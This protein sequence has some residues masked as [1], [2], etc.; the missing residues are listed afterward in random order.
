M[1]TGPTSGTKNGEGQRT[2]A[3]E[4]NRSAWYLEDPVATKANLLQ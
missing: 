4:N 1:C 2:R 3:L